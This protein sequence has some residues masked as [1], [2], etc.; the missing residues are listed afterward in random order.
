MILGFPVFVAILLAASLR[1]WTSWRSST[2]GQ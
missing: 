1:P 2:S